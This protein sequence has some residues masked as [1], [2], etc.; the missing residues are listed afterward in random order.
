MSGI[1]A[2]AVEV[3]ALIISALGSLIM[4]SFV[5]GWKIATLKS[6]MEARIATAKAEALDEARHDLEE[7][8]QWIG[9]T[10]QN[11]RTDHAEY[12][13][14]VERTTA[15][16]DDLKDTKEYLSR[17]IDLSIDRLKEK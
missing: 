11:I 13:L 1:D 9:S 7:R 3:A 14:L 8:V 10:L 6:E 4:A 16:K 17:M 2:P 12:K 5:S 15:K